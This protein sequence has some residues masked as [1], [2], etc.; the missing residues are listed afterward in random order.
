[1]GGPSRRGRGLGPA[2]LCLSA[3]IEKDLPTATPLQGGQAHFVPIQ[4]VPYRRDRIGTMMIVKSRPTRD[5]REVLQEIRSR[6]QPLAEVDPYK[7]VRSA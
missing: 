7:L 3:A 4:T 1:M 6:Q 5:L 2:P